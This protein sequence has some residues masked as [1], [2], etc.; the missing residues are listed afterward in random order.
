[1]VYDMDD[2]SIVDIKTKTIYD[3]EYLAAIAEYFG[4]KETK[5][6]E[7]RRDGRIEVIMTAKAR[8]IDAKIVVK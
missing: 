1:M 4:L 3:F 7:L 2:Y 6:L 8:T 5:K